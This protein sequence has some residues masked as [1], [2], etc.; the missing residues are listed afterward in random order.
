MRKSALIV[1]ALAAGVGAFVTAASPPARADGCGACTV[2]T[3][4]SANSPPQDCG[5]CSREPERKQ[6][7][8]ESGD[9]AVRRSDAPVDHTT[10]P[11]DIPAREV[12]GC[13]VIPK[14]N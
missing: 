10:K 2:E 4:S 9:G 5:D 1:A 6:T 11:L 3:P 14:D 12:E 8:D 13:A 7:A